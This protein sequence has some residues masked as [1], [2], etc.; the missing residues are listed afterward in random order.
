MSSKLGSYKYEDGSRYIGQWNNKGLKAGAGSLL[1]PDSTR[2]DGSF[3]NG[4]FSGLGI[5]SYPDGAK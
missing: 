2:F 5:I 3:Q 4:L 1:L